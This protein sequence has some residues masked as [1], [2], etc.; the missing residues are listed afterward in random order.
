M[1]DNCSYQLVI[2]CNNMNEGGRVLREFC[3]TRND[4][5]NAGDTMCMQLNENISIFRDGQHE[6]TASP[7]W[8]QLKERLIEVNDLI[9]WDRLTLFIAFNEDK[10]WE[11]FLDMLMEEYNRLIPNLYE[12]ISD[13]DIGDRFYEWCARVRGT[14]DEGYFSML[15]IE[16]YECDDMEEFLDQIMVSD[17]S[18]HVEFA[19]GVRAQISAYENRLRNQYQNPQRDKSKG[20]SGGNS[21]GNVL[22]KL[23]PGKQYGRQIDL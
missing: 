23:P 8:G 10:S 3:G 21:S 5:I 13:G 12:S 9:E 1:S 17:D 4:A 16:A 7:G 6:Y 19:L 2:G 11:S 20:G 18:I 14:L 22:P 15:D